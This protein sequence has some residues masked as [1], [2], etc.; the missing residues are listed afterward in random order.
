[1]S[2]K[3]DFTDF[4]RFVKWVANFCSNND[5][6]FDQRVTI[7]TLKEIHDAGAASNFTFCCS[8][9]NSKWALE[10]FACEFLKR[11]TTKLPTRSLCDVWEDH[12]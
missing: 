5:F 12:F 1:M 8:Q 4:N 6:V 7:E 3:Y 2:G 10:R 9:Q 11:K